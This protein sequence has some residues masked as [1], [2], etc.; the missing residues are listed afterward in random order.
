MSFTV[1]DQLTL[2]SGATNE[3]RI[4]ARGDRAWVIDGATDVV[5]SPLTG[6]A[7]DASWFAE[8]VHA[9]LC[10]TRL[11]LGG[12]LA[13]LPDSL[14]IEVGRRFRH[15]QRRA[16]TERHEYPSAAAAVIRASERGIHFM[17]IGDCT[18]LAA[19]Q[20]DVR[21]LGA[22]PDDRGDKGV[23]A[24]VA[25][26]HASEAAATADEA[27]R[28]VLPTIIAR[29]NLMNLAHGYGVLSITPPPPGFVRTGHAD[30]GR[31][32]QV[33]LA[34]DGLMRLVDVYG[35]MSDAQLLE[36]AT[37]RG[38]TALGRRLREIE[39]ADVRSVRYPRAKV[40]DDASAILLAL[41]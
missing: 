32:A 41:D 40:R 31:G 19:D 20:G 21:R 17:S 33:L 2:A 3:D 27:R 24:V 22:A 30:F 37:T 11:E 7:S 35:D 10:D 13:E 34:S 14:A 23:A 16:P 12:N 26:F 4:G 25:A 38:L 5:E 1:V 28:H 8:E 9:F 36:E 6:T 39:A 29:R 15:I 18:I